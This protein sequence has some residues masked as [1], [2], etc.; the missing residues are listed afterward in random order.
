VLKKIKNKD[1]Y[2]FFFAGAGVAQVHEPVKLN[3]MPH[4]TNNTAANA[5]HPSTPVHLGQTNKLININIP[6]S[7][8]SQPLHFPQLPS[9]QHI[10]TTSL[11]D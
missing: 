9:Q 8:F 4:N 10:K 5:S 3:I 2:L 6:K 11:T 7:A 1:I